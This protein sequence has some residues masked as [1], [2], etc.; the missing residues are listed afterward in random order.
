MLRV[1][2]CVHVA[3]GLAT[4]MLRVAAVAFKRVAVR[5]PLS[6]ELNLLASARESMIIPALPSYRLWAVNAC[7]RQVQRFSE[8]A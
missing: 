8:I 5:C 1:P 7:G 3:L 4:A 2:V 6:R